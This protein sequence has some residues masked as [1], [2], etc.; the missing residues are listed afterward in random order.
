[1]NDSLQPLCPF[2]NWQDQ[3]GNEASSDV[4][5][6]ES[7]QPVVA[8]TWVE[9]ARN[10]LGEESIRTTGCRMNTGFMATTLFW[11]ATHNCLPSD[12]TACFIADLFVSELTKS[13]PVIE[14]T[15]AAGAGVFD[16][17][18]RTWAT[19]LIDALEIPRELFGQIQGANIPVGQL[20]N[21]LASELGFSTDVPVFPSIGDHQ[22][23]FLGSV[24]NRHDSILLNVGTGAQVAV[25]TTGFDFDAQ[26]E[27]RPFPI[28]GNL[29]SNVGLAG[30]WSY[31]GLESFFGQI[32]NDL[33]NTANS[34]RLFDRITELA[35]QA[36]P[37][38]G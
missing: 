24:G 23:S 37:G 30:G 8:P 29:L 18:R 5:G 14:P 36:S 19:E 17:P 7:N 4:F 9:V 25:Y 31:Q 15:N 1:M 32:G 38:V 34:E 27:L 11:M 20:S 22:A 28:H 3:R 2:I 35:R 13:R 21:S 26:I 16:V 33:F 6:G 10:Q 12:G